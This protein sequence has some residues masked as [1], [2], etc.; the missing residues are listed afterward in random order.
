MVQE[1]AIRRQIQVAAKTLL[2]PGVRF[3]IF[4]LSEHFFSNQ[5][6]N[7]PTLRQLGLTVDLWQANGPKIFDFYQQLKILGVKTLKIAKIAVLEGN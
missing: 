7:Q 2:D 1:K 5:W 3:M 6:E 4:S